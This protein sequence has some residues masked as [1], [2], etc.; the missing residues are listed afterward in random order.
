MQPGVHRGGGGGRDRVSGSGRVSDTRGGRGLWSCWC[1]ITGDR[2]LMRALALADLFMNW[3]KYHKTV[4]RIM[5]VCTI[6]TFL[7]AGHAADRG[8]VSLAGSGTEA[9]SATLALVLVLVRTL[10]LLEDA[11]SNGNPRRGTN[12]SSHESV[13]RCKGSGSF[14]PAVSGHKYH[15]NI[16]M[17]AVQLKTTRGVHTMG[18]SLSSSSQHSCSKRVRSKVKTPQNSYHIVNLWCIN[19]ERLILKLHY[20][21]QILVLPSRERLDWRHVRAT[22]SSHPCCTFSPLLSAQS[23]PSLEIC[24]GCS[25]CFNKWYMY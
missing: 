14:F 24:D 17:I 12:T 11:G 25:I 6:L 18:T 13:P 16:K 5:P 1:V 4:A 23:S 15:L 7:H 10:A 2:G 19:T 21:Y 8:H 22:L 3:T 20:Y 9:L